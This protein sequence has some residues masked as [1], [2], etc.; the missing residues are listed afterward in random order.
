MNSQD[1]LQTASLI[2]GIISC[3]M[4]FLGF[5]LPF[6]ALGLI[7]LFLSLNGSPLPSKAIGGLVTSIIGLTLGIV[8]T[9]SSVYMVASGQYAR[10]LNE[11][12]Q[13]YSYDLGET[14]STG[15]DLI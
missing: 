8:V 14:G 3:V 1:R 4:I 7:F 11:V 10:I 13:Y 9:I 5:S 15:G 6:A 12:Q 2:M